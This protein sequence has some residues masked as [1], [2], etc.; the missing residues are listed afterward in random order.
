VN[1]SEDMKNRKNQLKNSF[2][3]SKTLINSMIF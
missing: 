1:D 2:K 3:W